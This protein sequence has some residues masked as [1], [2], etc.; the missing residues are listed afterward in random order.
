MPKIET[1]TETQTSR[2]MFPLN[3]A[4]VR[5]LRA[6]DDKTQQLHDAPTTAQLNFKNSED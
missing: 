4:M 1:N 5:R 6:H 3:P 2:D